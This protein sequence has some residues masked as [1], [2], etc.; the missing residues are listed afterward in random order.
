MESP[1]LSRLKTRLDELEEEIDETD[2]YELEGMVNDLEQEIFEWMGMSHESETN[3]YK[4]LLKRIKT[5]KAE[6]DFYDEER[7]LD[8]MFPDRHDDDFD[9]DSTSHDSVFGSD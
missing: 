4:K 9:E 8:M 5:I 2:S 1:E 7:E 6:N 3:G